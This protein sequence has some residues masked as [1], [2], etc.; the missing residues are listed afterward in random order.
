MSKYEV[1]LEDGSVNTTC[2][3]ALGYS[4]AAGTTDGPGEFDFTQGVITGNPFWDFISGLLKDPSPEQE[5]CHAPKPILLDTGEFTLPS[6]WH[7][8]AVDT[9]ILKIGK[10]H[11]LAVPGEL[12]TMA[13]RRVRE[14]VA[15]SLQP[16]GDDIVPVI[17]GLSNTYTHYV[18]TFE[19]YQKQRYEAASTIYGPNTLLAY[20]QQF[21]KLA[22]ALKVGEELP[23][24][25]PPDDLLGAQISFVPG[26]VYDQP[27]AGSDFGDCVVEPEDARPGDRVTATFISGHLRNNLMLEKTFLRVELEEGQGEYRIVAVDSDWET[28]LQ[29]LRTNSILGSSEVTITWDIPLDAV[30]GNYR[31][32]HLGH[33]KHILRGIT[34]YQGSSRIFRVGSE[35]KLN[36]GF[37]SWGRFQKKKVERETDDIDIF[38]QFFM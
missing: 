30:P 34:P 21:S 13:G 7:P 29:W 25:T 14:T 38:S 37:T 8:T 6:P 31:I 9:Q 22:V 20:Q 19:E 10:V 12:T 33:Y 23:A 5:A 35:I 15:G 17:A 27:P 11:L 3:P 32:V 18:T 26:V 24:G 1:T 16:L 28:K 36:Q 4:F 2:K